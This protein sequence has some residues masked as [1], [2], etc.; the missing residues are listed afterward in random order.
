MLVDKDFYRR[1]LKTDCMMLPYSNF[2]EEVKEEFISFYLNFK[3]ESFST[4]YIRIRVF[5]ESLGF[6]A[7][8]NIEMPLIYEEDRDIELINRQI[9]LLKDNLIFSLKHLN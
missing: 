4:L 7:E 1:N 2:I 5:N 6:I 8:G 9:K 3:V